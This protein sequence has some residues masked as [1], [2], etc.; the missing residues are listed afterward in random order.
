LEAA[1]GKAKPK[2]RKKK[3]ITGFI[4]K[5]PEEAKVIDLNETNKSSDEE[6]PNQLKLDVDDS[7]SVIC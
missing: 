6:S 7:H 2:P 4:P 3:L 5:K 1:K